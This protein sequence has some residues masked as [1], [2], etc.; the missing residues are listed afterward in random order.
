MTKSFGSQQVEVVVRRK[1][2]KEEGRTAFLAVANYLSGTRERDQHG[3][4]ER[5][6]EKPFNGKAQTMCSKIKLVIVAV[7]GGVVV[8]DF[9]TGS[10]TI[11]HSSPQ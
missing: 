6:C 8:W 5:I 1:K 3:G 10:V 9:V 2:Q 7:G 4:L 11:G